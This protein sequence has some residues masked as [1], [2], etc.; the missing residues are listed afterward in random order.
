[1]HSRL[2]AGRHA[3]AVVLPAS[4]ILTSRPRRFVLSA[5]SRNATNCC[6]SCR[7]RRTCGL[8]SVQHP[9]TLDLL[10]ARCT[11]QAHGPSR[12]PLLGDRLAGTT[13]WVHRA[14]ARG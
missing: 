8:P 13:F 3:S 12:C 6:T 5:W 10:Q 7:R 1:M 2:L 9:V 14:P 11:N 4:S